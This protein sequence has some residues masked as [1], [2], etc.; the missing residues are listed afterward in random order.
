MDDPIWISKELAVAIHKRQLAEHGG[1]DGIRDEGLLDSALARARQR[2]AYED[3][4]PSIPALAAAMA[5]GIARNH[6]F[7][8]GNKRTAFVVCRTFLILNGLDL[9]ADR[10]ERYRTFLE[11]A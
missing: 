11:L 8:D 7:I 9:T 10:V 4:T 6:A 1:A 3:P 5:F 2:F